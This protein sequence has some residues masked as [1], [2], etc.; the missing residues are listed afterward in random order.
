MEAASLVREISRALGAGC[1]L[2]VLS[3]RC[4]VGRVRAFGRFRYVTSHLD[5]SV[6]KPFK[7]LI[8]RLPAQEACVSGLGAVPFPAILRA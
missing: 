5:L 8:P 6:V 2:Y 4:V 7:A 3:I 1:Q